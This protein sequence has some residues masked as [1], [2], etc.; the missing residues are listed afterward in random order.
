MEPAPGD[1]DPFPETVAVDRE[2]RP[3]TPGARLAFAT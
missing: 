3:K 1:D 2:K